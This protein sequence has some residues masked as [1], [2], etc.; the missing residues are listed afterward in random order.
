MDSNEQEYLAVSRVAKADRRYRLF[1]YLLTIA[2][3][4]FMIVLTVQAVRHIDQTLITNAE[5]TNR[6]VDLSIEDARIRAEE[7]RRYI[8]CLLLVEIGKRDDVVQK[9][10]FDESNMEGGI[11]ETQFKSIRLSIS[12]SSTQ[13]PLTPSQSFSHEPEI[14]ESISPLP[15]ITPEPSPPQQDIPQ[16]TFFDR[17]FNMIISFL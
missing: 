10:C 13:E 17:L 16:P 11:D 12:E 1:L 4:S 8:T 7:T 5:S 9:R 3:F 15:N 2:L 6:K 14:S